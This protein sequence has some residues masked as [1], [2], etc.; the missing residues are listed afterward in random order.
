MFVKKK[1]CVSTKGSRTFWRAG[2]WVIVGVW[3]INAV[4]VGGGMAAGI[5]EVLIG[6]TLIG[7]WRGRYF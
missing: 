4:V 6:F 3:V 2:I 1:G 7:C 5:E